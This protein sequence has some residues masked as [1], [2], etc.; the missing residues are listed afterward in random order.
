[1]VLI[2]GDTTTVDPVIDPG[3]QVYDVAPDPVRVTDPGAHTV[4]EEAD[5]TTVGV[6]TLT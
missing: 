1:V 3:I 6:D 5:A 2:V 4:F